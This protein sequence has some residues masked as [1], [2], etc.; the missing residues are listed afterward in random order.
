M[1]LEHMKTAAAIAWVLACGVMAVSLD[2]SSA[3]SWIILIGL[4]VLP[5]LVLLRM[6]HVPAQTLSESIHEVLR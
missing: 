5:P 3:S 4:G 1:Q 2:V 6:W